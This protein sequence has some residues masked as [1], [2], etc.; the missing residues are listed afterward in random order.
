[1]KPIWQWEHL[2]SFLLNLFSFCALFVLSLFSFH[3]LT[4][5][6]SS[7][8]LLLFALSLILLPTTEAQV[9]GNFFRNLFRPVNDFFRPINNGFRNLFRFGSSSNAELRAAG[10]HFFLFLIAGGWC[11]VKWQIWD[12]PFTFF[13]SLLTIWQSSRSGCTCKTNW[14]LQVR[15]SCS[16]TTA[17]AK[18]TEKG[19]FASAIPSFVGKVSITSFNREQIH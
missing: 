11:C 19:N 17:V 2:G 14:C 7:R 3:L 5:F 15:T 16:R 12:G 10:D 6:R 13:V 18:T 1:M 4:S 8:L 9:F